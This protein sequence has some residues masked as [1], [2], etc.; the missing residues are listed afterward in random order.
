MVPREKSK[1]LVVGFALLLPSAWV[2][3]YWAFWV[4][5]FSPVSK[6]QAGENLKAQA[7]WL[8]TIQCWCTGSSP[9][10]PMTD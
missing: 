9:A 4:G 1:L 7:D 2:R 3:P 10:T 8:V 5:R 6:P